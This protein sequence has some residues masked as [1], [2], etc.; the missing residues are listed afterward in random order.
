MLTPDNIEWH[1][2]DTVG[3]RPKGSLRLR[4]ADVFRRGKER[5]VILSSED[6]V[7]RVRFC[8]LWLVYTALLCFGKLFVRLSTCP[9]SLTHRPQATSA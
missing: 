1:E 2:R 4:G 8:G 6:E 3:S 5:L 9:V 7:H